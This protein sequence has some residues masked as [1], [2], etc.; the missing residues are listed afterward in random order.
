M[1]DFLLELLTEEIPARMQPEAAV[2]LGERFRTLLDKAGLQA[3]AVETYV[4]PRR[5]ALLARGLPPASAPVVEERRGP[6]ADAPDAAI[7]G[8]L[9][10]T[11]LAR[12]QLEERET[13]RG[14]FLF[15]TLR[16]EGEPTAALLAERL[17][18]LLA[19]FAWP[20]AMRFEPTGFRWV[21]PL[22]GIVALLDG[23]VVP[24]A[25]AG[26]A[27]GRETMGH[28]VMGGG[29][30]LRIDSPR[31]HAAQLEAAFVLLDA[32]AR[33]ARIREGARKAAAAAGL[34]LVEDEG[35]VAENAGL[36]EWPVPLLGR[37][38]PAFLAVPPELLVLTM[39]VNQKY[40]ACVDARGQL[41]PAFV[42][43]ANLEAPDGGRA[44]VAG[45]ER[46]LAARLAD[47]RFF[48][49]QDVKVPL[50][51]QAAKL[52]GI[53]F[54]EKLGTMAEK[55]ERVARLARWLVETHP[56]QFPGATPGLVE[57][58]ARL[59]KADLVTGTVGEFPELQGVIGAHIADAQGEPAEVVAA[60]RQHYA[61]VP[62][63]SVPVAVAL[64]D[65]VDTLLAFF[66]VSLIPSGSKDP[67]ALRRAALASL[68]IIIGHSL[69][70][71]ILKVFEFHFL[72]VISTIATQ[73][74]R[75]SDLFSNLKI[76]EENLPDWSRNSSYRDAIEA[77]GL[78]SIY[79]EYNVDATQQL[80][81]FLAERLKV[82]ERDAGVR[83]DLIDAVFALGHE[84]DLVRL[85]ARVRAL[86]AFVETKEG[87]NLLAGFRR[88]ANILKAEEKK[89][90][91]HDGPVAP[92]L[93]VEPAERALDTALEG[94][95]AAVRAAVNAEDF[96]AAM[97]TLA[98][99][100]PFVDRFF[101]TV[102]VNADDP[103]LRRNRLAL[104]AKLRAT[105]A[106][107]ADFSKVEG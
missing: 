2:Q 54:H 68:D 88:A 58:A 41:A 10:S 29:T 38:D 1:A 34:A 72:N 28:R 11:G 7:A 107:V 74:A 32:E 100:R 26:V 73:A 13:D 9:K 16:R 43:I 106:L 104:L 27:S 4:T 60:L 55:V 84:D 77:L 51:A 17:P 50:D 86:Q 14:R 80:L 25:V 67:F 98:A 40:F 62:E 49:E 57:R 101:D 52:S 85:L 42:C 69:R 64:A 71:D 48:W 96:T 65:R 61:P 75:Q 22:R 95:Q 23:E 91:P 70:M 20:K 35:L 66:S 12:D 105:A 90:G 24:F 97:Q 59:A 5:L 102:T 93:L 39:K 8:F 94:A 37:F 83:H 78:T 15:A 36:A 63:G 47:A 87:E 79:F 92:A 45:N 21:R 18:A 53:L 46:V 31:T 6:R 30:A 82:R 56:G 3:E 89:D 33:K 103:G 44:I 81:T 19:G 76:L 99:L